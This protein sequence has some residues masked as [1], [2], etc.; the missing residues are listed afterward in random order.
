MDDPGRVKEIIQSTAMLTIQAVVDP[1]PYPSPEA[2]LGAKGGVLPEGSMIL[3]SVDRPDAADTGTKASEDACFG[4][5]KTGEPARC[6]VRII[7]L[8]RR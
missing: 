3:E 7:G 8:S 2:A 6:R 4:R 1:Q 5:L